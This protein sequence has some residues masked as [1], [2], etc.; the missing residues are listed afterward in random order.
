MHCSLPYPSSEQVTTTTTTRVGLPQPHVPLARYFKCFGFGAAARRYAMHACHVVTQRSCPSICP[1]RAAHAHEHDA[2]IVEQRA[3]QIWM[4]LRE[5]PLV[6]S[7][8]LFANND[9]GD[10][11]SP[12]NEGG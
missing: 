3:A 10:N 12:S 6:C 4:E 7:A 1:T 11:A 5:F 2:P 9:V 8:N